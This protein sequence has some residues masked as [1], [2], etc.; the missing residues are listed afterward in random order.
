MR[1]RSCTPA[2]PRASPAQNAASFRKAL[3]F[4]RRRKN[5]KRLICRQIAVHG[6]GCQRAAAQPLSSALI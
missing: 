6:N 1:F 3:R 4:V 2:A 5:S